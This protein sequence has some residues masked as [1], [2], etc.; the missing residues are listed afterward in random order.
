[1]NITICNVVIVEVIP[2]MLKEYQD[3]AL[4]NETISSILTSSLEENEAVLKKTFHSCSDVMFRSFQICGQKNAL[5]LYIDGLIEEKQLDESLLKSLMSSSSSEPLDD[6]H[7]IL[8]Y[9]QNQLIAISQVK[10]AANIPSIVQHVLKGSIVIVIAG[11]TEAL[12]LNIPG[13][14]TRAVEQSSAEATVRG[15]RD[16]FT[17]SI[18]TNTSLI[19]RRIRSAR[20]KIESLTVGELTQTDVAIAYIED[21]ASAAVIQEIKSR[22]QNI[23]ID[24][25]LES[26]YI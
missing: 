15:P 6:M 26:G 8:S 14:K 3:K 2:P 24:G 11:Q 22:I 17:E 20:L 18:R 19:C 5:L 21:I 9:L 1:M 16:S 25:V 23:Q 4:I 13:G 12:V 7:D 10:R